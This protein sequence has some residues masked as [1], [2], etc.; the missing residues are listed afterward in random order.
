[1]KIQINNRPILGYLGNG[2]IL[3]RSMT[4]DADALAEFNSHIHS[5]EGLDK[6]D[7]RVGTWTRD[8]LSRPHPTFHA[9]DF[10]LVVEATSGKIISSM[11][12][13]SQTWAYEGIPFG[14]GRPELVGTLP[15]YRNRGLVRHQF[16]EIHRWSAERGELLQGI[17]GIPFYYR[18]FGYEMGLELGGGRTGYEAQLPKLKEGEVEL[19]T[20]RQATIADIP[21]L[22]EVYEYACQQWLV[23]CVRDEAIWRY[24]LTGQSEKNIE[25][26]EFRILERAGT[27][28][29]VGY[30]THPWYDWDTG[31]E[32]NN[33]EIKPGISWL[34][35]TPTVARYLWLTGETYVKRDGKPQTRTTYTF[36]F[37]SE[38]PIYDIF[39]ERLPRHRDPYAWYIRVPDL[40]K[41]IRAISPALD[42]HIARSAIIG[43]TGET[44]ISFYRSGLRLVLDK[45]SLVSIEPWKP[46][47]EDRGNAA[48]PDLT[49]LQM[50]FGYRTF[51]ELEQSFADCWYKDDETRV[52]LSTLFP[53]KAS[54]LMFVK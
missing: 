51:E 53:K 32:A 54:A 12:L 28:E 49:F 14:V 9:D 5:E 31:L 33:F 15:E 1:M 37:G 8:L 7:L 47:N 29:P 17:T 45:G 4:G 42:H 35:V 20:V 30:F 22:M 25:R 11:N 16:E 19:F 50:V 21:F 13:I 10:T 27:N 18:L 6:P 39:R 48:F 52:L 2:L 44:R 3:C 34:E 24:E 26:L 23:T 41:F 36:Q 43:Y 40:P 46:S 38:H